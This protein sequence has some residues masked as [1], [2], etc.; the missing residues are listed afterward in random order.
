MEENIDASMKFYNFFPYYYGPFS[1]VSFLDLRILQ[2]K[3]YIIKENQEFGIREKA[4]N[5]I[6]SLSPIIRD[7]VKKIISR[8][9]RD[10]EIKE[11][12]Y[13]K[14]PEYTVKSKAPKMSIDKKEPALFTIGYEGK[15]I[16]LFLKILIENNISKLIDVRYNPFSMNFS[17]TRNKLENYLKKVR[18]EYVH[19][20]ELGI[21]GEQRKEL[22]SIEDYSL[23]FEEYEKSL[24]QKT[25]FI[26]KILDL[27][28]K[29]R[30]AFMCFEKEKERCHRGV[31]SSY[32]MNQDIAVE[33][34]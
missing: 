27:G 26:Q 15:D 8:F 19:I 12:V 9:S 34:L 7:K 11:Y 20:P 1:N 29:N 31:L 14:Y 22:N 13:E 33:H 18:I 3:G 16:D 32:I 21:S 2:A 28:S 24:V 5:C 30:I 23:L 17:F 10:K 25:S 4:I 6:N